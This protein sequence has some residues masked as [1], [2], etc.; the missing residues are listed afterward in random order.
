MVEAFVDQARSAAQVLSAEALE[1]IRPRTFRELAAAWRASLDR[2]GTKPSTLVGYDGMLAEPGSAFQ[3]G[4]GARRGYIMTALGDKPAHEIT[5]GDVEALLASVSATGAGARTVEKHRIM[6]RSI[7][8]FGIRETKRARAGT[9]ST[10]GHDYGL[11]INA[12][13]VAEGPRQRARG[14]LIY[15]LPE[16]VEAIA[17][18]LAPG[19]HRGST[20]R[21][22]DC[23]SRNLGGA[24]SCI[25]EYRIGRIR[26]PNEAS[27]VAYLRDHRNEA[28]VLADAQDAAAVRVS[29]Y[30][31]LRPGELLAL[32][33]SDIDWAGSAITVN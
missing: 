23:C 29:A 4:E 22:Q 10:H 6:V 1:R 30:T 28:D 20:P 26:F 8:N 31:G 16:E 19:Q 13:Q 33:W 12:A 17:C 9:G 27:A 32:R 21:H 2:K 18:A 14:R 11:E 25:P 15:Y 7:L 24:C 3:R 5:A